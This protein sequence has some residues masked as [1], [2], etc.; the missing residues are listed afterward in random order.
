MHKA[1]HR[2]TVQRRS[3]CAQL[4]IKPH[5]GHI[6]TWNQN[7]SPATHLFSSGGKYYN[8]GSPFQN[9]LLQLKGGYL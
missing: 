4:D 7:L 9:V 3:V 8:S 5:L 2:W 6:H 1:L